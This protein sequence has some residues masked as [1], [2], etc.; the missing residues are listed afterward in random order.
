MGSFSYPAGQGPTTPVL[1][2]PED[3]SLYASLIEPNTVG[4]SK[5]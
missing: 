1:A 2:Q 3:G 5:R 4:S